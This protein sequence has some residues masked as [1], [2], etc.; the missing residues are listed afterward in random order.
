MRTSLRC[1]ANLLHTERERKS[2][3][4]LEKAVSP[5]K[6]LIT[7]YMLDGRLISAASSSIKGN[8]KTTFMSMYLIVLILI[9][10]GF[11]QWIIPKFM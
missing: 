11:K 8:T 1:L 2:I 10:M 6:A 4:L 7:C 9:L 3:H 5:F